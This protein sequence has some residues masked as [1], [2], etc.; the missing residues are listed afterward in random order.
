MVC[1][2][3]SIIYWEKNEKEWTVRDS[4]GNK[5]PPLNVAN[6]PVPEGINNLTISN[7]LDIPKDLRDKGYKLDNYG[8]FDTSIWENRK[9]TRLRDR[10]LKVRI[11]YTGNDLAVIYAIRTLYTISY[12]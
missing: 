4:D 3:P 5:Y 8:S 1:T 2:I 9:E 10:F 11:R 12:V 7:D 6:N